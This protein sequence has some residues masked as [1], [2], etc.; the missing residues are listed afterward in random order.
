MATGGTPHVPDHVDGIDGPNVVQAWDVFNGTASVGQRVVVLDDEHH[1]QGLNVAEMLA[2]EG[3]DVELVT[4][5]FEVGAHIEPNTRMATLRRVN[6]LNVSL[7]P[8]TWAREIG[9]DYII[10]EHFYSLREER[11]EVDTVVL[12]CNIDP[13]SWLYDA[14][15]ARHSNVQMAG[16]C[17]GAR[18]L[19]LATFEGHLAARKLEGAV[20]MAPLMTLRLR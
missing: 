7:K 3:K 6:D 14:L 4:L 20:D 13:E 5:E 11:K 8:T 17:G 1:V 2:S 16:D 19:E 9:P 12:A 10:L 15:S 18:R